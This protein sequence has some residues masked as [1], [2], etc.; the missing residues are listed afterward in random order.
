M[1]KRLGMMYRIKKKL[2][3]LRCEKGIGLVESLAAVALLGTAVLTLT[4]ALA[5]GSLG[6]SENDEEVVVQS[7]A[8]TQLEYTKSYAYDPGASTYP[9]VAAPPGYAISVGVSA[10]PGANSNIQKI[11]ANISRDGNLILTIRDYKGNRS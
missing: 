6:V 7:L 11:T 4:G 10:V 3:A 2:K 9:T 8:R 5:T 1:L